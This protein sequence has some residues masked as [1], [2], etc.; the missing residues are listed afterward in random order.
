M[1]LA[2]LDVLLRR[3]RV[4]ALLALGGLLVAAWSYLLY[5]ACGM[6]DPAMS[7]MPGMPGMS[8]TMPDMHPWS[9]IEFGALVGMWAVMM[10]AMM[11][12]AAAPM[13]L[14]FAAV[15]RRRSEEGRPAVPTSIFLLGYL[16]VWSLFSVAA[17]AGQA[18][19]HARAL[20]S[21]EM[22]AASPMLVGGLLVAAG[23][24]QWTPL[25]RACLSACRSPLSFLMS[26]W[27]EGRAGSFLLGVQ[28][29]LYCLGCCWA[30]MGLLFVAG[31]MNLLWVAGIAV[32]VLIEKVAPRGDLLAR[33][34]GV[35]LVVAGVVVA[36]R[37]GF[38]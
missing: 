28:H 38:S 20:L 3:D 29:G 21:P 1:S 18:V 26:R 33:L 32:I 37:T 17:A 12:P 27:R 13:I 25:K 15:H 6:A 30:L 4:I 2:A 11:I 34:A 24:F 36:T 22:S 7:G 19:L 5:L 14:T 23:V 35:A 9:W 10:V 16:V 31:V 8:I